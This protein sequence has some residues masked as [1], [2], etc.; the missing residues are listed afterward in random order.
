M[1]DESPRVV[2]GEGATFVRVCPRCGRIVK[3]DDAL[4]TR[5]GSVTMEPNAT[6][7]RCGRVAMPFEGWV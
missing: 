6:C 2:Y 5:G 7:S 4:M 3:A 1:S